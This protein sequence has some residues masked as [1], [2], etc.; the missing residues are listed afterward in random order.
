MAARDRPHPQRASTAPGVRAF[1][2]AAGVARAR[3]AGDTPPRAIVRG[4]A[5]RAPWH[6]MRASTS[7][8][9][10]RY[11]NLSLETDAH[12]RTRASFV[13]MHRAHED[14]RRP[15]VPAAPRTPMARLQALT[16]LVSVLSAS[17]FA[18]FG[19]A[20]KARTEPVRAA[21]LPRV[22]ELGRAQVGS[23]GDAGRLPL[24]GE[25]GGPDQDD[26]RGGGPGGGPEFR[27]LPLGGG[28]PGRFGTGCGRA[29]SSPR[30]RP[31][32]R[33]PSSRTSTPARSCRASYTKPAKAAVKPAASMPGDYL[34]AVTSAAPVASAPPRPRP[35]RPRPGR[36]R[37]ARAQ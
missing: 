23:Q 26:A 5:E 22:G 32:P 7:C 2:P 35:R 3:A 20:S 6:H 8:T 4:R 33:R 1:A 19:W 17:A 14:A 15:V 11:A 12:V 25:L 9:G 36:A 29:R 31:R 28:R 30:L 37:D 21:R 24:G 27:R 16:L 13:C 18:P 10:G 34:S